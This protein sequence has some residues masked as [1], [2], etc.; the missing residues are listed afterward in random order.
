MR[1]GAA[2]LQSSGDDAMKELGFMPRRK[3]SF[4]RLIPRLGPSAVPQRYF[5]FQIKNRNR[6]FAQNGS[7]KI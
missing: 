1:E 3:T 7:D 2:C 6:L 4:P 5:A